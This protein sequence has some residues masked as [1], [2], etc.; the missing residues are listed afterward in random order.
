MRATFCLPHS[1]GWEHLPNPSVCFVSGQRE[2][3]TRTLQLI[4]AGRD[5]IFGTIKF[6]FYRAL[7]VHRDFVR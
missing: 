3:T 4:C 1:Q 5:E 2:E 7:D 6:F